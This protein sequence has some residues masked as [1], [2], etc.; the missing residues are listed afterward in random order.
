MT[1]LDQ[2]CVD[3]GWGTGRLARAG[4]KVALGA[5][6]EAE[7][8]LL[9]LA[10]LQRHDQPQFGLEYDDIL[11]ELLLWQRRPA[12]ALDAVA[13]VHTAVDGITWQERGRP[14]TVRALRASADL[15]EVSRRRHDAEGAESAVASGLAWGVVAT[16]VLAD[17]PALRAVATAELA[18]LT[19]DPDPAM[20]A[21]A[22]TA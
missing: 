16:D 17:A 22:A 3:D 9:A 1:L 21:A 2:S 18:R 6:D 12:A 5:L 20:W 13:R 11:V 8:D 4:L 7:A 10:S 19:G 14:L 15:A